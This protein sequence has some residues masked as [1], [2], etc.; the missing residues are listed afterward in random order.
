MQKGK[1]QSLKTGYGFIE[2][3]LGQRVFFH[4]AALPDRKLFGSLKIGDQLEFEMAKDSMGGYHAIR[5][6][7]PEGDDK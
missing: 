3:D 5:I 4:K 7:L 6:Y 2:S 1:V